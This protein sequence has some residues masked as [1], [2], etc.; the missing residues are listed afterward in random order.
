MAAAGL[1][2]VQLGSTPPL[3]TPARA[4]PCKR[5][6]GPGS[7]VV[8]GFRSS[9]DEVGGMKSSWSRSVPGAAAHGLSRSVGRP[10]PGSE[11]LTA[12]RPLVGQMSIPRSATFVKV[13]G[14]QTPAEAC[15]PVASPPASPQPKTMGSS[16][17]S[18]QLERDVPVGLDEPSLLVQRLERAVVRDVQPTLVL[19]HRPQR[20][21]TVPDDLLEQL[22]SQ[23]SPGRCP[24]DS[25]AHVQPAGVCLEIPVV[26]G[27]AVGCQPATHPTTTTL[28]PCWSLPLPPLC[29]LFFFF[30]L[31]C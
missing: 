19:P 12:A 10:R 28:P 1:L 15:S 29:L 2:A 9:D 18:R 24:E 11:G 27:R 6:A 14:F 20:R 23:V 25:T 26:A 4:Q 5:C 7:N 30:P 16:L 8:V 3:A 22:Q 31:F 13:E 21:V 17:L